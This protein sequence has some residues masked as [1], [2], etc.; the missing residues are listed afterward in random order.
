MTRRMTDEGTSLIAM[1]ITGL[2]YYVFN[3]LLQLPCEFTTI[4]LSRYIKHWA[5]DMS[6]ITLMQAKQIREI[7]SCV[8]E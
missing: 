6:Q 8:R 5:G 3:I 7:C 4:H 2:C 1:L